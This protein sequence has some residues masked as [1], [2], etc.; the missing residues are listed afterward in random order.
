MNIFKLEDGIYVIAPEG[1][2]IP[3][4]K[5]TFIGKV[6]SDGNFTPNDTTGIPKRD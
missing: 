4:D 5:V 1:Y 6:D 2:T 3:Q